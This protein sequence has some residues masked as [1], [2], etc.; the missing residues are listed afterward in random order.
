VQRMRRADVHPLDTGSFL[1]R[2]VTGLAAAVFVWG[3]AAELG[4]RMLR[5]RVRD[6]AVRAALGAPL[7]YALIGSLVALLGLAHAATPRFCIALV[8]LIALIRLPSYVSHARR[9]PDRLRVAFFFV[10]RTTWLDRAA[11]LVSAFALGTALVAAALPGVWW[12]PIAYHLPIAATALASGAFAFDP[13]MVQSAFPALGEAAALPA[14]AIAGSAGAAMATLFAGVL[15]AS[16]CAL[17]ARWAAPGTELL[18]CALMTS[19][20]LWLW[21]GPSFYVDMPFA[22]FAAAAIATPL[23]VNENGVDGRMNSTVSRP[24]GAGT[25]FALITGALCGALAGAAAAIKY[26]GLGAGALALGMLI[27]L[28]PRPRSFAFGGFAFGFVVLSVGWYARNF[29]QIGDPVYPF[30][31]GVLGF[32]AALT[33]FA[34]RYVEMTRHWCGTPASAADLVLLP[35]RLLAEPRIFCGDQGFALR[36]GAIFALLGVGVVRRLRPLALAS[37]ALTIVWFFSS[38][39]WRFLLS[40]LALYAAIVAAATAGA[41]GRLR[42]VGAALLLILGAAGIALNWLPA[43]LN[44]AS[45]SI[46]PGFAYVAGRESPNAYLERRLETFGASEWLRAHGA[47][48]ESVIALDDVRT[49]YF[50]GGIAWAN[51]YYQQQWSL[52]WSVPSAE[53]YSAL[54]AHRFRYLLVN[55]SPEYVHRT[56]TGVNWDVLTDD[57]KRGALSAVYASDGVAVYEIVEQRPRR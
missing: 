36:L 21:L 22:L 10:R 53:R 24:Q 35:W 29:A 55:A 47:T 52:N 7:G 50:W 18:A 38:Q 2:L 17:L 9:V 3:V 27:T 5:S 4:N 37:A 13:G 31:T 28:G 57:V 56:P 54:R 48:R 45:S 14:Y 51:P 20:A 8:T 32:P 33:E 39:Q 30:L 19:S 23:L 1:P 15:L 44:Q 26:S 42:D 46:V 25:T 34:S 12:D 16:L 49:Y 41:S 6:G 11:M 40:A 43:T